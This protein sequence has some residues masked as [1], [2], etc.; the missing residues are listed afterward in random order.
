MDKESNTVA[1]ICREITVILAF[2]SR[3]RLIQWQMKIN[4]HLGESMFFRRVLY[5]S[6]TFFLILNF[7]YNVLI[8][9]QFLIQISSSPAKAKINPGPAKLH[10]QNHN[11]CLTSGVPSKLIGYWEIKHLRLLTLY[12]N[13]FSTNYFYRMYIQFLFRSKNYSHW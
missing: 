9:V 4:N 2:D 8:G 10:I 11:F 7:I 6:V 12:F 5:F 1:I 13:L 3:E